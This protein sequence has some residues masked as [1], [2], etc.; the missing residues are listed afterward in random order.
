MTVPVLAKISAT[1]NGTSAPVYDGIREGSAELALRRQRQVLDLFER[2]QW[3][4]LAL[5]RQGFTGERLL[6]LSH[7]VTNDY[8]AANVPYITRER[9]EDLAD[10]LVEKALQA[11]LRFRPTHP[12]E[13]YATNGG[14]HYDSWIAD[15]MTNRCIDWFRAKSEGNGDRRYGNDGR[16]ELSDDP[17]PADHDVD[18]T[19]LVGDRERADWQAAAQAVDWELDEWIKITLNKAAK[20]VL[21]TAAA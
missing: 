21:E 11:T 8:L 12:T 9:R 1:V 15:I 13:S 4:E 18:F 14:A 3:Y 17:D 2:C 6:R 10:F 19:K 20:Y 7:K 5:L 16:L